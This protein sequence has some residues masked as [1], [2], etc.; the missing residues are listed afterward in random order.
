MDTPF[1][2]R[3]FLVFFCF[4]LLILLF[5]IKKQN[6]ELNW[7]IFYATLW[8][9]FSL[10]VINYCAVESNLW[11][12]ISDTPLP[13]NM[14][15]DI[16]FIWIV[17][18]SVLPVYFFKGKHP[19]IL[20]LLLFWM[21][22][23]LMP[24]L[25]HLSILQLNDNWIL[26]EIALILFVWFPSYLWA[27][28]YYDKICF[29][30]R[31]LLQVLTMTLF[32]FLIIPFITK[33][34][35]GNT[36]FINTLNPYLFQT[37]LIIAFPSL[38]AVIDLANK[39]KGT[40]FPYDKT[41]ILVQ[42]GVYAYCK[43]PIQW[44]FTL[45]FIPL[46]IY[47]DSY[48]LLFGIVVSVAYTI[49]ISNPQENMDMESR[50]GKAWVNY[51]KTVPSWRFLWKPKSIPKGTIYFKKNC[52]QC[53]QLKLWFTKKNIE[54][55]DIKFSNEYKYSNLLQVTYV[56]H[57]D[58]EHKS[59]KAIAHA[60]EHINLAYASLGWFMRFPIVGNILQYVIDSMDFD[61]DDEDCILK[62]RN[63]D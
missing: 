41:S 36:F 42:S 56:D 44:S 4:L 21:D 19:L 3:S 52:N 15:L 37:I 27:R 50:F 23:V 61:K 26:G 47:Y 20:L 10:G 16:F 59:I 34:Y 29:K 31:S 12:F 8:T 17:L 5:F 11:Y 14:P 62:K 35:V 54:S 13:M 24:E 1:L 60:L 53:E 39:G 46:S 30:Y 6:T 45:I 33:T 38:C 25:E 58:I 22:M 32:L 7:S 43:N 28:F 48:L 51:K 18:W 63:S 9:T 40:P 49:G 2:I 55:L 57:M